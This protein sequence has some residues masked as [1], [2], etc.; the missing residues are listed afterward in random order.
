MLTIS[1]IAVFYPA[2]GI[3]PKGPRNNIEALLKQL[4][5]I[6]FVSPKFPR[7]LSFTATMTRSSLYNKPKPWTKHW[8]KQA[9]S[10]S[11]RSSPRRTRRETF[12]PG[13]VKAVQW[14]KDK[15][16]N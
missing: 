7:R 14:F 13:L 3:D 6:T 5:P 9:L 2:F 12:V 11:S 4:S 8:P 1:S 15:L 16:V 10:T